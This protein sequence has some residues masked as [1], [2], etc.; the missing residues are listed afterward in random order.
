VINR[1]IG[2]GTV[3]RRRIFT[4]EVIKKREIPPMPNG[5]LIQYGNWGFNSNE[6]TEIKDLLDTGVK[7][8]VEKI[9]SGLHK[10]LYLAPDKD[11]EIDGGFLQLE[12]GGSEFIFL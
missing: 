6:D 1:Q 5:I 12:C 8:I 7:N 3:E 4:K 2:I 11:G 9:R 10:S